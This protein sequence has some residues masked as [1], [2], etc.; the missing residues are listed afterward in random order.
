MVDRVKIV[1]CSLITMQNLVVVSHAMCMHGGGPKNYG[2]DET[3]LPWEYSVA[4]ML[5]TPYSPACYYSLL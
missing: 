2:D 5:E 1:M 4:D 3:L